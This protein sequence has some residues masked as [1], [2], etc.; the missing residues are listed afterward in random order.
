MN[1]NDQLFVQLLYI[2]HSSGMVALG[3]LKNPATDKIERNLEQAKHSIDMLEMLKVKSKGNLSDD[4][5]R[6]MDT[7]LSELKLNYVDEFNKDKINT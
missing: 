7:F 5:L 1:N 3:K 4:L 6:M 2:F